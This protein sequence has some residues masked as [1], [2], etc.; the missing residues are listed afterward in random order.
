[1]GF[2]FVYVFVVVLVFG[3][4]FGFLFLSYP[5]YES[6][7]FCELLLRMKIATPILQLFA[8][9]ILNLVSNY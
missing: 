8:N 7:C 9:D 6:S 1:M 4:C 3:F 2:G 5:N